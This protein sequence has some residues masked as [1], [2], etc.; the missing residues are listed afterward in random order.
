MATIFLDSNIFLYAVGADEGLRG[1]CGSILQ[2]AAEGS[3][4][5]TTNSEVIQEILHVRSQIGSG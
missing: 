5:A 3:I 4:D 1:P 2:A